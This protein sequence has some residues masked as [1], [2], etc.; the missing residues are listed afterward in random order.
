ME[1][2]ISENTAIIKLEN[3]FYEFVKRELLY[4]PDSRISTKD[5]IANML[6]FLDTYSDETNCEEKILFYD[7]LRKLA[8]EEEV[9]F[10]IFEPDI[11]SLEDFAIF[12]TTT[13]V[14]ANFELLG[15]EKEL[16]Y[17]LKGIKQVLVN[18]PVDN[19]AEFYINALN[20]ACENKSLSKELRSK[21]NLIIEEL[22]NSPDEID[23]TTH[24]NFY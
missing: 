6:E 23:C 20:R 10:F 2:T 17:L 24:I 5:A 22:R 9:E 3:H 14:Y 12:N 4:E 16:R 13:E 8:E 1:A 19:E 21:I 11:E 18:Y 15:E 7:N